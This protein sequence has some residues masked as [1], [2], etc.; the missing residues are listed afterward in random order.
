MIAYLEGK[1]IQQNIHSVVLATVSGVGY[2]VF[3]PAHTLSRVPELGEQIALHIR[4]IVREDSQE[5]FGFES[6]D[7]RRTFETLIS[8]SKVGAKTALAIL[9][10]YRPD[11]LRRIVIEGDHTPLTRVSGIGQKTAQRLFLELKDKL[12]IDNV[13]TIVSTNLTAGLNVYKDAMAGLA[14]LG[15]DEIET[16]SILRSILDHDPTLDVSGALRLALRT[17]A[18]MK[19]GGE[20]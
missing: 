5:L 13:P 4:H 6:W 15:Y 7:E 14:G 11:D 12:R 19:Q 16:A 18:R 1:L 9:S 20:A 10:V 8:L 2:E 3:I 17:L